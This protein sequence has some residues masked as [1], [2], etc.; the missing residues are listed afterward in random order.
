[1]GYVRK[2]IDKTLGTFVQNPR[3][4]TTSLKKISKV[5]IRILYIIL[6]IADGKNKNGLYQYINIIEN[7]ISIRH[8][9]N[10]T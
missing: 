1:M 4:Q 10:D 8:G 3:L 7:K 9:I 5:E 6:L 2:Q